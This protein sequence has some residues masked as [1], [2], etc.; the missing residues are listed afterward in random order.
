MAKPRSVQKAISYQLKHTILILTLLITCVSAQ[1]SLPKPD[2]DWEGALADYMQA[3]GQAEIVGL[4]EA[5]QR[6]DPAVARKRWDFFAAQFPTSSSTAK[7]ASTRCAELVEAKRWDELLTAV[8]DLVR[9]Y[10]DYPSTHG[11][12]IAALERIVT[13]ADVSEELRLKA[14]RTLVPLVKNR[15]LVVR[16]C[17]TPLGKMNLPEDERYRLGCELEESCGAFP[18]MRELRWRLVESLARSASPEAVRAACAAFTK[19]YGSGHLEARSMERLLLTLEKT[20]EAKKRLADMAK[21]DKATAAA[22]KTA[23]TAVQEALVKGDAAGVTAALAPLGAIQPAFAAEATWATLAQSKEFMAAPVVARMALLESLFAHTTPGSA[24]SQAISICVNL[25]RNTPEAMK[26]AVKHLVANASDAQQAFGQFGVFQRFARDAKDD[27]LLRETY[28]AAAGMAEKLGVTDRKVEYLTE[29]AQ[30]I[31]DRDEAAA[32][33]ALQRAVAF[34]PRIP[35]AAQAGWFL[36]FLEGKLGVVQGALPREFK[37]AANADAAVPVLAMPK[38]P[39]AVSPVVVKGETVEMAAADVKRNL[40]AAQPATV[41]DGTSAGNA[42]TDGDAKTAWRPGKLPAALLVPLSKTSTVGRIRVQ[43]SAPA[44]YVITLRDAEGRALAKVERDWGFWEHMRIEIHWPEAATTLKLTPVTGVAAIEVQVFQGIGEVRLEELEAFSSPFP[45]TAL[46]E[47]AAQDIAA[48][49][50]RVRVALDAT[51]PESTTTIHADL[52][53]TRGFPIMR[54]AKPWTRSDQPVT[55]RA[56]NANIGIAFWGESATATISG[57]GGARWS[58]DG[59][60]MQ[61]SAPVESKDKSTRELS[62]S[63]GPGGGGHHVLRLQSVNLPAAKDKGGFNDVRLHH[64]SVKGHAAVRPLLRFLNAKGEA[65]EWLQAAADGSAAVPEKVRGGKPTRVQ[66][67]AFFDSRGVAGTATAT[68]RAMKLSFDTESAAPAADFASGAPTAFPEQ[69]DAV[70]AGVKAREA[71]V[72]YAKSGTTREFAAAKALAERAGLYLVSDD[73]GLN[74]YSTPIIAVG[75]PLRHRYCR[76]LLATAGLWNDAAYLND[77]DGV[78]GIERDLQDRATAYHITGETPDAVVKAVERL[79]AKLPPRSAQPVPFRTFTSHT[80][81]MVYPWQLHGQRTP[82]APLELRLG[83]QDRRSA[84]FGIAAEVPLDAVKIECGALTSAAGKTIPKVLVQTVGNYEWVPFFGDL[85]LPNLLMPNAPISLPARSAV[86]VWLT[87]ITDAAT[88]SGEYR[89]EVK[90][91]AAGQTQSVPVRVVV[92]PV[93]LPNTPEIGTYSFAAVPYWFHQGSAVWERALRELAANEAAQDV[94][95]VSP[96]FHAE[97]KP[98]RHTVPVEMAVGPANSRVDSLKWQPH[99]IE[100][101]D[102]ARGGALFMRFAK[103]VPMREIAAVLKPAADARFI[104]AAATAT[105]EWSAASDP[106]RQLCAT[107][108][109]RNRP[110]SQAQPEVL[111]FKVK[112]PAATSAVWR[113][114]TQD[115]GAFTAHSAIALTTADPRWPFSA[116]FSHFDEQ[117][118]LYEEEYRAQQRPLPVF[119]SQIHADAIQRMST[120]LFGTSAAVGDTAAW[121]A[122]MMVEHLGKT[123]RAKRFIA[124][125]GDEPRDLV[126]WAQSAQPYRDGGLQTMTAHNTSYADMNVGNGLINPWCPNYEHE[127]WKPFFHERRKQGDKVWWYECGI[128]ATRITGSPIENL[129]FYWLT[130]KWRMDGAMN[131]AALHATKGSSMPLAFRYEHGMDHRMAHEKNGR[132]LDTTR[133]ELEGDGIRDVKLITWVRHRLEALKPT[134]PDRAKQLEQRLEAAIESVVPYRYGFPQDAQLW[135]QARNTVYDLAAEVAK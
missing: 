32:K 84:Q 135:F 110:R 131:Y 79:L 89:G 20:P 117:M 29:F 24:Q 55:M 120:D 42:V 9:R 14:L 134:Q 23:L 5:V 12:A 113:I 68:V 112:P 69:M 76:Q 129:P 58:L 15:A 62:F 46:H 103:P 19:R 36:A 100:A 71:V 93:T 133:R 66:A 95:T 16:A 38:L 27:D 102:I 105:G 21:E 85:R 98:T 118:S 74:A 90:I 41:S 115:T 57:T 13:K 78:L 39:A 128:P 35:A 88:P 80:L 130:A 123:G 6:P 83:I 53:S 127:V 70:L 121:F 33:A 114:T 72:V 82:P 101:K 111:R 40:C 60:A 26:L 116:D 64:L 43:F 122:E 104:L 49:A 81:E 3:K 119:L 108:D 97:L 4:W 94:N 37:P 126:R 125:V 45:V 63:S 99:G 77:E 47:F 17:L 67:A 51:Q 92:E 107:W 31:W 11:P 73:I 75:T 2:I 54:W 8:P 91:T 18:A 48:G 109:E 30:L 34:W 132:L 86:G 106:T 25:G 56:L 50:K 87:A 44:Y 28:H 96:V 22:A 1:D 65:S 61:E 7:L 10:P 59:Q 52:E 124:K